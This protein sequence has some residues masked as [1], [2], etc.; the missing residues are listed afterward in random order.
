MAILDLLSSAQGGAF[1]RNVAAATGL[2]E[3]ATKT[4]IGKFAPAI[5][6]KLKDKAAA[7]PEAFENL[8]DLLEDGDGSDLNDP[9]AITGSEAVSDGR[10]ILN[11]L[12]GSAESAQGTL[13]K[14]APSLDTAAVS[15]LS[16]IS[17]TSVLAAL[18]ASNA[19]TL[20]G[21]T[22]Q[23]A[24]TGS[25]GGGL[26]ST[27]LSAL[28]AGLVKGATRQLAPRRR[29]RRYSSYY[30]YGRRPQRRRRKRTP[31]LNDVFREILGGR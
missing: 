11:D 27:I 30:G 6:S 2:D 8:L 24:D 20:T 10:E 16:A 3:A 19:Q 21:D 18:A 5:A 17:A 1:F 12:Y 31:G 23:A 22:A 14:L 29:R 13:A 7:D 4:A 25:S 9:D 28:V 15:K 26:L